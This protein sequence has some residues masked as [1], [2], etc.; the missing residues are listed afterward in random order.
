[1]DNLASFSMGFFILIEAYIDWSYNISTILPPPPWGFSFL[2]RLILIDHITFRQSYHRIHECLSFLSR[3]ILILS[4]IIS[5]ILP[6]ASMVFSFLLRLI[7]IRSYNISTILPATPWGF[8]FLLRVIL[9]DHITFRQSYHLLHGL[10]I[11]IGLFDHSYLPPPPW[12]FSG[13]YWLII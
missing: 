1:M 6:P 2:L 7:L 9:I 13:L 3:V 11:L 4:Y 10:F 12:G 8:S 5:T